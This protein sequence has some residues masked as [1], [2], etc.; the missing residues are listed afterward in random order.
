MKKINVLVFI[1]LMIFAYSSLISQNY[2]IKKHVFGASASTASNTD[3]T[4][5]STVGQPAIGIST[6]S[7]NSAYHGFWFSR[8]SNTTET[9]WL[10]FTEG[11]NYVSLHIEPQYLDLNTIYNNISAYTVIVR[12]DNSKI[13]I[14]S[15]GLNTIGD[16]DFE[17]GYRVYVTEACSLEVTG[18]EI[19]PT[20][21]TLNLR[22]GWNQ[23]GYTRNSDMDPVTAYASML[24]DVVIVRDE[25]GN[26][27]LPAYNLNTIGDL[28]PG[29]GYD[30]YSATNRT[31]TY[32]ANSAKTYTS[33]NNYYT[34]KT[35]HFKPEFTRTAN[36]SVLLIHTDLPD[37]TEIAVVSENNRVLG[38]GLVRNNMAAITIWGDNDQTEN[39]DGAKQEDNLYLKYFYKNI[40]Q[41]AEITNLTSVTEHTN[42]FIYEQDSYKTAELYVDYQNKPQIFV[43]PNPVKEF[44]LI[45]YSLPYE[46]SA[47]VKIVNNIGKTIVTL[48]D[49]SLRGSGTYNLNFST[50]DISQGTY[51]IILETN[52]EIISQPVVIL[53]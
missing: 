10:N 5:K 52:E 26:I 11:W 41:K 46:T 35:T 40:E 9:I 30:L 24:S 51:F 23:V 43:S 50:E 27:C 47:K 37:N 48:S 8:S 16:W 3:Y 12:D 17:E 18:N 25:N 28:Q 39:I 34:N 15:M 31:F 6:G 20:T 29:E 53:K 33:Q 4:F 36:S 49:Y 14:P 1:L 32:P 19:N 44:G 13:Y 38:A 22:M 45:R 21:E 42:E 2:E 7:D